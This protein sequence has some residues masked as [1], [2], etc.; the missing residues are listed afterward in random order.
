LRQGRYGGSPRTATGRVDSPEAKPLRTAAGSSVYN[1]FTTADSSVYNIVTAAASSV[2]NIVHLIYR[3]KNY[4]GYS[5]EYEF[6]QW[7]MEGHWRAGYHDARRT[8]RHP[9]KAS[10][11]S[12]LPRTEVNRGDRRV[13]T[14]PRLKDTSQGQ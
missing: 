4:E 7:S 1:I 11:L 13:S 5:K 14:A 12:I 3:A 8:P 10:L 9:E 2:Y 6:S